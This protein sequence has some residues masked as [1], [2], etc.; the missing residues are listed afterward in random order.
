MYYLI[1]QKNQSIIYKKKL[2]FSSTMIK[3][4]YY[5]LSYHILNYSRSLKYHIITLSIKRKM[6]L[7]CM[8][9]YF[10]SL[11]SG[12]IKYMPYLCICKMTIYKL[13]L[14]TFSYR[15]YSKNGRRS[16]KNMDSF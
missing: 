1:S 4:K 10:I 11:L 5:F 12:E 9:K 15:D 8:I 16:P 13:N 7:K 2:F 14:L 6:Y 3:K